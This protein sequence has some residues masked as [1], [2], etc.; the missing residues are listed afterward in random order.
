MRYVLC[1][2]VC[3]QSHFEKRMPP[4]SVCLPV[5]KKRGRKSLIEA[6]LAGSG[7]HLSNP[8]TLYLDAQL[9][10]SNSTTAAI[11]HEIEW[12]IMCER[13]R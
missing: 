10:Y 11:E 8:Q 9:F 5:E 12:A 7:A 1:V 13:A 6:N 4:F 3:T 2:S